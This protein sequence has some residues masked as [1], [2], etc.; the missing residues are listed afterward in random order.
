MV[1]DAYM[2][3]W[4]SRE[5]EGQTCGGLVFN[6]VSLGEGDDV[7]T[8]DVDVCIRVVQ[9]CEGGV[10]LCVQK[11]ERWWCPRVLERRATTGFL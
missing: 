5:T 7:F 6:G 3:G 11:G 4:H 8:R 2:G 9:C 1:I 10:G